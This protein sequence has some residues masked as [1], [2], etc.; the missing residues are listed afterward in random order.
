MRRRRKERLPDP[1]KLAP[2]A[3]SKRQLRSA[4]GANHHLDRLRKKLSTRDHFLVDNESSCANIARAWLA[5]TEC[6]PE[7]FQLKSPGSRGR[8]GSERRVDAWRE[9]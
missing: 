4:F 7:R 3:Y 1:A 9:T 2:G 6:G 5:T 8:W